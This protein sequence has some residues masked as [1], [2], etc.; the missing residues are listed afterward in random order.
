MASNKAYRR[1]AEKGL[2]QARQKLQEIRVQLIQMTKLATL[3]ELLSGLVHEINNPLNAILGDLYLL[4]KYSNSGLINQEIFN[5]AC[6]A[7]EQLRKVVT[8]CL[9]YARDTQDQ[10]QPVDLTEAI[11]AAL[12]L[13]KYPLLKAKIKTENNFYPDLPYILGDLSKLEQVYVSLINNAIQ[14]MPK[15]GSLKITTRLLPEQNLVET[16]VG[17]SGCG[18]PPE[19][20]SK[21]FDP[22]FTT[23]PLGQG[24]G[25]GLSISRGL[26]ENL[27]GRIKV[28]SSP[29]RGT[30]FTLTFPVHQG[31]IV[32]FPERQPP[33]QIQPDKAIQ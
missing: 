31:I 7:A 29:G 21:I 8:N 24:T 5:D 10:L 6:T 13:L 19:H 14:A 9:C 32:Q 22:F 23:K 11:E 26:V 12:V 2:R 25:L 27:R 30:V 18:I 16:T 20:L 33:D 15:G 1:S 4:K 28:A 17:D 3:G